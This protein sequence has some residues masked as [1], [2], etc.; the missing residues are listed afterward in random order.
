M[1][2][3][4][5][6]MIKEETKMRIHIKTMICILLAALL[7]FGTV[8]IGFADMTIN[9]SM[10]LGDGKAK[11]DQ[12]LTQTDRLLQSYSDYYEFALEQ[13][14]NGGDSFLKSRSDYPVIEEFMVQY[15]L[16]YEDYLYLLDLV[17]CANQ[18]EVVNQIIGE[19]DCV[20]IDSYDNSIKFELTDNFLNRTLGEIRSDNEKGLFSKSTSET[21]KYSYSGTNAAN[22]ATTYALFYN[23]ANY[24]TYAEDCANFVSQCLK[25]G[26]IPTNGTNSTT[27]IYNSTTKWYC[28]CTYEPPVGHGRQYAVTTS[29]IRV[30]DFNTYMTGI[31]YSKT[32]KYS[33]TALYNSCQKGDAVLLVSSNGSPY[34]AVIISKRDSSTAYYCGHTNNRKN[35]PI[36]TLFSS[37]SYVLLFDFT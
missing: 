26:G 31:A 12:Y 19:S 18:T 24:P 14:L 29:W 23:S 11:L 21:V 37:A 34:H 17:D 20:S 33:A 4:F 9:D 8:T 35:E 1:A 27:G 5:V 28:V 16:A 6:K 32:A 7:L 22:Y 2:N 15:K 36:S 10:T 3:D 13:L 25:A 30:P